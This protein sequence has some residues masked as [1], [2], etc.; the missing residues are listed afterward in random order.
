[1]ST[2]ITPIRIISAG[3]LSIGLLLGAPSPALAADGCDLSELGR[4]GMAPEG[5][6]VAIGGKVFVCKR[7]S[8]TM[9]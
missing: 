8:W 1:M 3:L 9:L 7:G 6:Q 4:D 5:T 2:S